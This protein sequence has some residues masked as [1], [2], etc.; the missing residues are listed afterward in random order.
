MNIKTII[1]KL[2]LNIVFKKIKRIEKNKSQLQIKD[3]DE[4][5]EVVTMDKIGI[6]EFGQ[7]AVILKTDDGREFPIK[8]TK[9][10]SLRFMHNGKIAVANF[11][12]VAIDVR[13]LYNQVD[14]GIVYYYF[15]SMD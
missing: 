11:D 13:D 10:D 2:H 7:G 8:V 15:Q 9:C 12:M 5:S 1:E 14:S 4:D 6:T 3:F